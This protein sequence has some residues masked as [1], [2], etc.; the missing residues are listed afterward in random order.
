MRTDLFAEL[1]AEVDRQD[2]LHGS[3]ADGPPR[4]R[5]RLAIAILEDEVRETLDAWRDERK[6]DGWPRTRE[7]MLQ[8]AAVAVRAMRDAL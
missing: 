5:A 1:N 7:E 6:V 4:R 2:A 8:V 3:L